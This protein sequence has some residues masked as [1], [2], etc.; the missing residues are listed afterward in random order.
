MTRGQVREVKRHFKRLG[1]ELA[2]AK[3]GSH[4]KFTKDGHRCVIVGT[5][6]GRELGRGLLD[7][8]MKD[9]ENEE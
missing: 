6:H 5:S 3:Q 9:A 8:I 7:K 4:L 1:W 2:T